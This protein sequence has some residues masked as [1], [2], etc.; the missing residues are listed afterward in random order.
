MASLVQ[1]RGG[2][3]KLFCADV[4]GERGQKGIV[5]VE[6]PRCHKFLGDLVSETRNL[7]QSFCVGLI[8]VY[9]NKDLALIRGHLF[10]VDIL[11]DF[12]AKLLNADI[13]LIFEELANHAIAKVWN[14][15]QKLFT[16]HVV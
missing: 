11:T 3:V 7:L 10:V 6:R 8:D 15:F 12:T 4:F 1:V 5:R 9:R 16:G 13:G 2:C 14:R